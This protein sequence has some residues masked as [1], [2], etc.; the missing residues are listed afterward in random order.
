M[1]TAILMKMKKKKK[2]EKSINSLVNSIV[3]PYYGSFLAKITDCIDC[4]LHH[5]EVAATVAI[6]A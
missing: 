2:V 3:D 5:S 4:R 1:Y 6:D